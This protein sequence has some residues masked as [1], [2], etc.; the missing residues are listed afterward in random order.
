MARVLVV[1]DEAD[2]REVVRLNLELDGHEVIEAGGG[3]Q[4]LEIAGREL[5][6]LVVLDIMMPGL[7]GWAVL[8][9]MKADASQDLANIPVLMLTARTGELDRIR[10]G[11]EGAVSYIS[12]PFSLQGLRDAV[13]NALAGAPE[14]VQRREAQ[15]A[16]LQRLATLETGGPVDPGAAASPRP[17][18]TRLEHLPEPPGPPPSSARV[19]VSKVASLSPKQR[20]LLVAVGETES[21][22]DAAKRLDVS[23]SNVYASLARIARRLG[24]RGVSELVTLARQ[25]TFSPGR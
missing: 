18:L 4:A 25:G 5:P 2:I 11:I 7:D 21:V 15:R 12:K 8:E 10:G 14:P 23:R 17:H 3:L 19:M 22:Q 1:D 24:V 13:D 6:E 9:R 16:A 20:A